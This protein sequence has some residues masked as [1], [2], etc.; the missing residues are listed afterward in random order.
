VPEVALP[1]EHQVVVQGMRLHYLD[2]RG[3]VG[4]PTILFLHGGG[5]NAHTWD[6]VCL[7][8]RKDYRCVALDQ[9][10][11]GDSEWSPGMDYGPEAHLRDIEGIVEVLRAP[12]FALVGQSMGGLNGFRY[13]TLH[14]ERLAALVVIDTGPSMRTEGAERILEFVSKTAEVDSLE[15]LVAKAVAFNPLRDPRLLRRSLLYN[16]RRLPSGKWARKNDIRHLGA[17]G[18][19]EFASR[20]GEQ[21]AGAASVTCPTL[22]LRGALS[23]VFAD[24]NAEA[25]A[26]QLP[27]G[28][29]AR[30]EGAGHTVQGDKPH[31]LCDALHGF[32]ASP[33]VGWSV[34]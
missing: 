11:H 30:I 18:A 1:E 31:A 25:F 10:G 17:V 5:L 27:N 13:A 20:V 32:L 7:A 26:S 8:L 6:V 9:R 14:S 3:D 34:S 15:D 2:W 12:R 29:W 16:F 23:D 22:V 19:R 4:R 21:W 33:E 28:R 24:E